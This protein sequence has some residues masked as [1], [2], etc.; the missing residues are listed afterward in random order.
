MNL[1]QRK[2]NNQRYQNKTS[3]RYTEKNEN[4]IKL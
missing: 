2:Q 4:K 3:E 1:N